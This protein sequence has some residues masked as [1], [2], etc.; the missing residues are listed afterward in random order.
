MGLEGGAD[1]KLSHVV[2]PQEEPV[3]AAGEELAL[4]ARAFEGAGADIEYLAAALRCLA[5]HLRRLKLDRHVVEVLEAG[6]VHG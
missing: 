3:A 5:D 6:L 1:V 4:Q 2:G